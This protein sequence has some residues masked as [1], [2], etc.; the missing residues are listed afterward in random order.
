L[1]DRQVQHAIALASLLACVAAILGLSDRVVAGQFIGVPTSTWLAVAVAVPILH[2]GYVWFVWRAELHHS[3]ITTWLGAERGWD[4]YALGFFVL[5]GARPVSILLVAISNRG[6]LGLRP[7][8]AYLIAAVLLIPWVYL[9]Y[10]VHKY[11]GWPRALGKDHFDPSYREL[12]FVDKGMFRYTKNGMYAFGLLILWVIALLFRSQ[13]ALLVAGFSH[14]YI[15]VHYY[16]TELPDI[17]RIYGD[18]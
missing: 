11:F 14:F 9:E 7:A 15:W 10:S 6:T 1:F 2:Q 8:I 5:F 13:A 3:R 12:P 16:C 18:R 17:R 4:Y